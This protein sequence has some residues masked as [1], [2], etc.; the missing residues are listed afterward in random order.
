[1]EEERHKKNKKDLSNEKNL[2][3]QPSEI[4]ERRFKSRQQYL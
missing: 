3:T 1:M 4:R 2:I